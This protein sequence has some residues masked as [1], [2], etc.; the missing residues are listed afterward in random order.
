LAGFLLRT[1][2]PL[3]VYRNV[4]QRFNVLFWVQV[5]SLAIRRYDSLQCV[6]SKT[7]SQEAR[8]AARAIPGARLDQ[9]FPV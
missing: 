1:R 9:V 3:G 4:F 7:R 5:P 8:R 2:R 6:C